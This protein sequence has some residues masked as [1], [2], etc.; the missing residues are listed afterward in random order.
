[1][2]ED[3]DQSLVPFLEQKAGQHLR[4]VAR[5]DGDSLRVPF[6]R[7]DVQSSYTE[8]EFVESFARFRDQFAE[9]AHEEGLEL[10]PH[11]CTVRVFDDG[12]VFHYPHDEQ[13]GT[14]ISVDPD[15]ADNLLGF[16]GDSLARME[17]NLPE[18]ERSAGD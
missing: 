8:A 3:T 5:Y 2:A 14:V 11:H 13:T 16:V 17:T 10:G 6:V 1:V 7:D 4:V 12:L 9:Q 18:F 15:V